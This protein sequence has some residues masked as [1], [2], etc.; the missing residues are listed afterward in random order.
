MTGCTLGDY[1]TKVR[2]DKAQE[3]MENGEYRVKD[4]ARMVG[5]RNGNY[6]SYAFKKQKGFAP[7]GRAEDP[8]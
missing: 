2:I 1:L 7:S 4:V 5:Y 8:K 6:F 3:I